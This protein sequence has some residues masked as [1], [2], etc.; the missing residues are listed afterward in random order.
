MTSRT[1]L[2]APERRAQ[3][4]DATKLLIAERG[5]EAVS[6][7]AIARA[8]GITRP[9]VYHHFERGL[10][11]LLLALLDRETARALEQLASLVT[12]R[13]L[14]AGFAAYLDAVA[15]DPATWQLVLTPPEGTP[16]VLRDRIREGR[17]AFATAL[18]QGLDVPDPEITGHT[19]QALADEGARLVL[20]GRYDRDR[21]LAHATWLLGILSPG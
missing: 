17:A 16:A 8:A 13:D 1:R 3:L 9:I 21:V 10:D 15:A 7:E 20:S 12:G 19:L 4:L 2:T 14:V 5:Y 6:I 11:E 18:A